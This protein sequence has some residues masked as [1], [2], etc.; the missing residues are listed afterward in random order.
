M[1]YQQYNRRTHGYD[2]QRRR[3]EGARITN[4][5]QFETL[6]YIDDPE[7]IKIQ[8][9]YINK[10]L[11]TNEATALT[12]L[13]GGEIMGAGPSWYCV[14][15]YPSRLCEVCNRW[16]MMLSVVL[17]IGFMVNKMILKYQSGRKTR[18]N[19]RHDKRAKGEGIVRY[20]QLQTR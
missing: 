6:R 18:T 19:E 3:A 7:G 12:R 9:R 20:E 10:L 1:W 4:N 5:G 16:K 11:E 13:A 2:E 15:I 14:K 17:S 8:I